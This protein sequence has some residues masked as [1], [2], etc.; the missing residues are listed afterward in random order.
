MNKV[1]WKPGDF[2]QK[3]LLTS[4]LAHQLGLNTFIVG[5]EI[6]LSV[7]I[8]LAIMQHNGEGGNTIVFH[9]FYEALLSS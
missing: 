2:A 5:Q 9:D 7:A 8:L 4:F 6:G 3:A 1:N